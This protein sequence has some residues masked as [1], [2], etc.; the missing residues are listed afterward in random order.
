M[1]KRL[2]EST[3]YLWILPQLRSRDSWI[4]GFHFFMNTSSELYFF[5]SFGDF[6]ISPHIICRP[7]GTRTCALRIYVFATVPNSSINSWD[8]WFIF[9]LQKNKH[10][11]L[12][13]YS[14]HIYTGCSITPCSAISQASCRSPD[15]RRGAALPQEDVGDML[16]WTIRKKPPA[17]AALA[18]RAAKRQAVAAIRY[19]FLTVADFATPFGCVGESS[20]LSKK[21]AK[22][23]KR[24]KDC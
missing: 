18:I 2:L 15:D 16:V 13:E 8:S 7:T 14:L 12:H 21:V 20:S 11:L 3:R 10:L 1:T 17:K 19:A 4:P 22:W 24:L 6:S 9:N 23:Y 5:F